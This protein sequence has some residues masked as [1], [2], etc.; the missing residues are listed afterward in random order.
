M[1]PK[2]H[3]TSLQILSMITTRN[4]M[5]MLGITLH[6]ADVDYTTLPIEP[7]YQEP[8]KAET[9]PSLPPRLDVIRYYRPRNEQGEI[10]Q[11]LGLTVLYELDYAKRSIIMFFA[12]CDGS[13]NFSK[14]VGR[15]TVKKRQGERLGIVSPLALERGPDLVSQL[16]RA[17]QTMEQNNSWM[18]RALNTAFETYPRVAIH[19]HVTA[20]RSFLLNHL[21]SRSE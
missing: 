6:T 9:K 20:V 13:D 14:E 17:V 7:Q 16:Y 2:Q 10:V 12:I 5:K 11:N 3:V 15:A 21:Y 8:V 19:K 4:D 18:G 1:K